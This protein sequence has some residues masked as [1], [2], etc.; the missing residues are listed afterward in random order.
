MEIRFCTVCNESIPDGEFDA[1]R[2]IVSGEKSQHVA[3]ALRRSVE[4]SGWRSW[5]TFLLALFAAGVGTY[6][7]VAKMGEKAEPPQIV[8][9]PPVVEKHVADNLRDTETRLDAAISAQGKD[10]KAAFEEHL[11]SRL[12]QHGSSIREATTQAMTQLLTGSSK[13]FSDQ[14]RQV[15][16]LVIKAPTADG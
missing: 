15:D 12:A 9:L 11:S 4:M 16:R 3:C 2:A 8:Q 7:L 13:E 5:F 6:L 10:L 14:I 1:G